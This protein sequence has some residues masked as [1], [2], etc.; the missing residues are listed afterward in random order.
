MKLE[1]AKRNIFVLI[2]TE[3]DADEED[4]MKNLLEFEEIRE[5]HIISGQYDMLAVAEIDLRRGSIFS[6]VQELSQKVVRKMRKVKG[7][8]DTNTIVPFLTATR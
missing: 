5:V 6:T 7:I 8:R 2:D 4:L 3:L 1:T